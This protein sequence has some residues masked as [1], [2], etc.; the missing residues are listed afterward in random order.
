MRQQF[1]MLCLLIA[2]IIGVVATLY[3]IEINLR[4]QSEISACNTATDS[5]KIIK[6]K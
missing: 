2:S 1:F 5:I 3:Y 6:N 4:K